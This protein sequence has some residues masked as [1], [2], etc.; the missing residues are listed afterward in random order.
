MTLARQHNLA[1]CKEIRSER[2]WCFVSLGA[3]GSGR[4][5]AGP[6]KPFAGLMVGGLSE[7]GGMLLNMPNAYGNFSFRD[8]GKSQ[9]IVG[10]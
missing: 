8:S 9:V 10:S 5:A 1:D 3:Q 2:S 4:K 6:P 7:V